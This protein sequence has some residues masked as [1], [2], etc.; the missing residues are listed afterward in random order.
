[1]LRERVTARQW[2]GLVLGLGG[3]MLV[4][5]QKLAVGEGTP[6]AVSL[7]IFALVG[8]TVGTLYQKR[9]CSHMNLRTGN[10]I[11]F[12]AAGAA[13]W[14]ISLLTE[15]GEVVWSGEFVFALGWLVV[16]LSFGAMTLLYILIRRGAAARVSSLFFLVPPS[17][18]VIAFFLFG[19]QLGWIALFGMA[20]TMVGVAMVNLRPAKPAVRA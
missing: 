20:L 8:I 5:E 2:A 18:A 7:S 4:V 10:A 11:Q 12:T 14:L 1:M 3:V 16:V 19:E 6:F 9:F 17:T 13:V 15:T